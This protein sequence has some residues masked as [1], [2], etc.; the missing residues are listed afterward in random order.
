M[1]RFFLILCS[2]LISTMAAGSLAQTPIPT[3]DVTSI[4][5]A[6]VVIRDP[7]AFPIHTSPT[8]V[9]MRSVTLK[10]ANRRDR[11]DHYAAYRRRPSP[12]VSVR[13]C[14]TFRGWRSNGESR[15]EPQPKRMAMAIQRTSMAEFATVISRVFTDA[16]GG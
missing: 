12:H 16:R 6:S 14:R 5:P 13:A 2:F 10:A 15:M 11:E 4:H 3:F 7:H 8:S 9:T 1:T